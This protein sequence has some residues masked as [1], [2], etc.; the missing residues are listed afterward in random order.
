ALPCPL[1][2]AGRR[3]RRARGVVHRRR[4]PRMARDARRRRRRA[5]PRP[6]RRRPRGARHPPGDRMT[7]ALAEPTT[8]VPGRWIAAFATAW[9]GIWMAQLT[10]VQLQLP[11]QVESL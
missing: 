9:L 5:A 11:A 8:R 6:R 7:T 2:H 4:D 10:P 3:P 1:G